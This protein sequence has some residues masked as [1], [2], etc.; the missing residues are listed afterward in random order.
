MMILMVS[1]IMVRSETLARG[2]GANLHQAG[3]H[4]A[5]ACCAQAFFNVARTR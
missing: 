2:A 4:R 1:R 5:E 3:H